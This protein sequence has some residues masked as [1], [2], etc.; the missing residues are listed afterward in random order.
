MDRGNFNANSNRGSNGQRFGGVLPG[1]GGGQGAMFGQGRFPL[2]NSGFHPSHVGRVSYLGGGGGRYGGRDCPRGQA[3]HHS[4]FRGRGNRGFISNESAEAMNGSRG[5]RDR[6]GLDQVGSRD[7]PPH[8]QSESKEIISIHGKELAAGQPQA[9][10]STQA[11]GLNLAVCSIYLSTWFT[12][13]N[14]PSMS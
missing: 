7:R 12:S 6:L 2:V 14:R 9:E 1:H 8:E 3:P 10:S 11:G 4:A 13:C 5:S